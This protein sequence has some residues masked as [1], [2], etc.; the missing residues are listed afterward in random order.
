MVSELFLPIAIQKAIQ[1]SNSRRNTK[2]NTRISREEQA[3]YTK[4]IKPALTNL[5]LAKPKSIEGQIIYETNDQAF[6]ETQK[7]LTQLLRS[8]LPMQEKER[9]LNELVIHTPNI[10]NTLIIRGFTYVIQQNET[11][12]KQNETLL[13]ELDEVKKEFY[14]VTNK[15]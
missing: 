9:Q 5:I 3:T 2:S 6:L 11:V 7:K 4:F 13:H 14:N 15:L 12:L 8:N 10:T 1:A